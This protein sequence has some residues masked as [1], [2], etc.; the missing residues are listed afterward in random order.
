MKIKIIKLDYMVNGESLRKVNNT[1]LTEPCKTIETQVQEIL[2]ENKNYKYIDLVY[3]P[4]DNT[5]NMRYATLIV[6]DS[7]NLN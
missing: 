4:N 6:D 7:T 1:W 2:D 5:I 3:V